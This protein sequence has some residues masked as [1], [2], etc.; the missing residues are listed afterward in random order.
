MKVFEMELDAKVSEENK[1]FCLC[2]VNAGD[3]GGDGGGTSSGH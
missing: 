3:G 2:G 1:C